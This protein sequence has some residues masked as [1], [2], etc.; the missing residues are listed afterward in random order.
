MLFL[1]TRPQHSTCDRL[2]WF[3]DKVR[4]LRGS[5]VAISET[6]RSFRTQPLFGNVMASFRALQGFTGWL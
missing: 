2:W 3:D 4:W 6:A 1:R 5:S